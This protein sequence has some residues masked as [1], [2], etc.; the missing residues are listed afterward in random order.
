MLAATGI[1]QPTPKCGTQI[2][3]FNELALQRFDLILAEAA[4]NGIYVIFPMVDGD[5]Y[6]GGPEWYYEQATPSPSC[7]YPQQYHMLPGSSPAV[8]LSQHVASTFRATSCFLEKLSG[9]VA[10]TRM[11]LTFEASAMP[12]ADG[13][14]HFR[15]GK[16][17]RAALCWCECVAALVAGRRAPAGRRHLGELLHQR[18]VH[19]CVLPQSPVPCAGSARSSLSTVCDLCTRIMPCNIDFDCSSFAIH[20]QS[21][22]HHWSVHNAGLM[23]ASACAVM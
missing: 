2:G 5:A 11:R 18:A 14:C 8:M 17:V 21:G 16:S 7:T 13:K 19:L 10:C 3:V 20:N 12:L 15:G 6:L 9:E 23:S 1:S 22:T 4:R